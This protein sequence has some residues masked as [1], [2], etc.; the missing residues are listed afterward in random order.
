[1]LLAILGLMVAGCAGP[2]NSEGT[3]LTPGELEQRRAAIVKPDGVTPPSSAA[4]DA[5]GSPGLPR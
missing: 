1:M 3:A 2:E 4:A 5:P